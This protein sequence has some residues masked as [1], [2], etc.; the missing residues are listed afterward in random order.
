[1]KKDNKKNKNEKSDE[2][3]I[4]DVINNNLVDGKLDAA[5]ALQQIFDEECAKAVLKEIINQQGG[6]SSV[7][8]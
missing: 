4:S 5:G 8:D 7:V 1:M 2:K 6:D 3:H